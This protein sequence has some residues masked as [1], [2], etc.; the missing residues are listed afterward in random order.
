MSYEFDTTK[1][2]DQLMAQLELIGSGMDSTMTET[3]SW[4]SD[5]PTYFLDG[6]TMDSFD[7]MSTF[8]SDDYEYQQS[9]MY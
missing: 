9:L 6:S 4:D 3:Y 8:D 1:T 5:S 2:I 7:S